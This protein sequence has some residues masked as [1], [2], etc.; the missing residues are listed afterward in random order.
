MLHVVP[1]AQRPTSPR[2]VLAAATCALLTFLVLALIASREPPSALDHATRAL[3]LST[4]S[5]QLATPMV[6]ISTLGDRTGLI[7]LIAAGA[8]LTWRRWRRWAIALPL[9]MLGTGALQL[10]AKWAVD[11]PRPS[12][13]AWGFPSGHVL[14]LVVLLGLGVYLAWTA[15]A[16]RRTRG[17]CCAAA[18]LTLLAVGWSRLYL[19]A[20]WL[21]D[22]VGG[23]SL[24]LAYLLGIIWVLERPCSPLGRDDRLAPWISRFRRPRRPFGPSSAAGSGPISPSIAA[25][26]LPPTTS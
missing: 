23:L 16:G 19:E 25:A 24:G 21:S 7:G 26:S 8:V 9:A 6:A 17:L 15:G 14:S 22:L 3:V 5:P 2:T 12:L 10:A 13:A 20:H 1:G 18:A 4:H 11:R